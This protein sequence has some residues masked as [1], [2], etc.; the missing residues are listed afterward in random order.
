MA[1]VIYE[2]SLIFLSYTHPLESPL[3]VKYVIDC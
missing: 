3:T 2:R 1:K